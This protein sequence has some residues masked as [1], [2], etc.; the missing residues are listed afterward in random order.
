MSHDRGCPCGRESYDYNECPEPNC[1]KRPRPQLKTT[2][3]YPSPNWVWVDYP[4]KIGDFTPKYN[5]PKGADIQLDLF[6]DIPEPN[7]YVK[8]D[9]RFLRMAQEIGTWSK[10]PSTKLGS[11]VIDPTSRRVL[12][13]GYNGFPRGIADT[14]ERLNNREEKY[15]LI[16]HA[17]MNSIYNATMSGVS[18]VGATI[19]TTGLPTCSDCARGIIQ[20]GITRVVCGIPNNVKDVNGKWAK[21]FES[22]KAMFDE[23]GIKFDKYSDWNS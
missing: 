11:I 14:P 21:Q 7:H 1:R 16:V 8:W 19:Y 2:P 9:K 23:V 5:I 3:S 15:K 20:V 18:L 22:S 13:T 17:E 12:A 10:D 4:H 6:L